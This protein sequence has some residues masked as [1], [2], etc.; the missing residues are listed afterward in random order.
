VRH[1]SSQFFFSIKAKEV[2]WFER[3]VAQVKTYYTDYAHLLNE[4]ERKW[5]ILGLSLMNLLAHNRIEEFHTE[6]EL[7][8]TRD[9]QNIYISYPVQ[10]EQRLM[11]GSYNKILTAKS[12]AK[13]PAFH[14]FV[15]ILVNTVREKISECNEK[16]YES[17]PV[18]DAR[19]LLM[20]KSNADLLEYAKKRGWEERRDNTIV[21]NK[22]SKEVALVPSHVLI[23]QLLGYATEL[24]RI[25]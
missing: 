4:S 20:F 9:Q 14:F 13:I 17:L 7:I 23:R 2:A 22:K 15:D 16:A 19:S 3:H 6:L 24:E 5:P 25:V 21:F 12:H 1:L 18:D 8:P 10:L 11:E